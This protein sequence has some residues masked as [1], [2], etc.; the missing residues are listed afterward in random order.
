MNLILGDCT[1]VLPNLPDHSFDCVVTDPPYPMIKRDYGMMTESAWF[2]MMQIVVSESR[3]LLKPTGSAVFI[4]QPNSEKVGKM[5]LWL[6]EFMV[7]AGKEWGIV[8]DAYWWNYT[9]IPTAGATMGGLMRGSVKPC[10]WVG[11]NTC[12]RNQ[13]TVLWSQAAGGSMD[14]YYHRWSNEKSPSGQSVV[15]KRMQ[16]SIDRKGGVTPFNLL[17]IPNAN[18]TNSAGSH[19]HGAGT[20]YELAHWWIRYICPPGGAVLD[21]FAGSGTMGLAARDLGCQYTGI[22]KM[23]KHYATMTSRLDA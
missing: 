17:P 21:P 10:I 8:Q 20:P 1:E 19:G 22:E 11:D 12:H 3:R 18:S 9:A 16:E 4:L 15:K 2:D 5:R 13:D 23:D 6:W 7:W 14:R